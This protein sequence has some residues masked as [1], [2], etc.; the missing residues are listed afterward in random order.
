MS[1]TAFHVAAPLLSRG[2]LRN[3][4]RTGGMSTGANI[5]RPW[6]YLIKGRAP[7]GQA[8]RVLASLRAAALMPKT[9]CFA[10]SRTL[11]RD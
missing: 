2:V 3:Q 6:L 5:R 11:I 9:Y 8:A 7:P 10:S 1:P 4:T